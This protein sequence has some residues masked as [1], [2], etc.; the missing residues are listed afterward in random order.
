MDLFGS[1]TDQIANNLKKYG[2]SPARCFLC[3]RLLDFTLLKP[4]DSSMV[5][6]AVAASI[7][8][9]EYQFMMAHSVCPN[10]YLKQELKNNFEK[11]RLFSL[12]WFQYMIERGKR[13][14]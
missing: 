1:A 12:E 11:K 3:E 8:I 2:K 4:P 13:G 10:C 9:A 7:F 5:S 14:L 6:S